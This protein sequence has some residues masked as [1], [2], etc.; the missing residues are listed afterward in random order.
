MHKLLAVTAMLAL[1]TVPA[2]AAKFDH[3]A[4]QEYLP[5]APC[6]TCHAEG[7]RS[8]VPETKVCLGCH[9]EVFVKAVELPGLNTHGPLWALNHR[10]FAKGEA[11]DC[12]ACHRQSDCLECHKAG[13]ADE[14][15]DFA[16][17][18]TN[19][20]R[21]DFHV[22]HP[23]AA[24]TNPQLCSSCHESKF[25]SDCHNTF[26]RADLAIESHRRG[27]S[28]LRVSPSGPGVNPHPGDWDDIK[29]RLDRASGGRTCRRC[30]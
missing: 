3:A 4:H 27:W 6:A 5:D 18:M 7:A 1:W 25:C 26:N 15:G 13:F 24:R 21:S 14:Q 30:H 22:T 16:N 10:P 29:G 20:H 23:I 9:E 2:L 11:I 12:A 17:S 19:V 28:D 8:I